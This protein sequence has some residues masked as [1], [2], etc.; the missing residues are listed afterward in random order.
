MHLQ[1]TGEQ[2]ALY[3]QKWSAMP[4]ETFPGGTY[5]YSNIANFPG[6]PAISASLVTL[7]PGGLRELHWHN[8]SEWAYV[9]NGTCRLVDSTKSCPNVKC[10]IGL[11]QFEIRRNDINDTIS[12]ISESQGAEHLGETTA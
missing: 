4:S 12:S 8:A 6:S 3:A 10:A 7:V 1:G 9:L 11:K 2:S 5:K